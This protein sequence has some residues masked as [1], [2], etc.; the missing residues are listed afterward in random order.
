MRPHSATTWQRRGNLL[1]SARE[2]ITSFERFSTALPRDSIAEIRSQSIWLNMKH[3]AFQ[4]QLHVVNDSLNPD[5]EH[6]LCKQYQKTILSFTN[7]LFAT[8]AQGPN[9]QKL[10]FRKK[11]NPS[12]LDLVPIL[13]I[14][15]H[16]NR[17]QRE[18]D[19]GTIYPL[20]GAL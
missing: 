14:L 2:Y 11:P 8:R 13:A 20:H 15:D 17:E 10:L 1:P 16:K 7:A 5:T 18:N 6:N 9:Y 4:N 3:Y 19:S 12:F